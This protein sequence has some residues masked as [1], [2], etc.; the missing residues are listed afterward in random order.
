MTDVTADEFVARAA[1]MREVLRERQAQCE[2]L[3]RLPD[4]TNREYIEAGFFRVLQPR[5]FGG[6]ELGLDAFLRISIELAR[7][8]PSSGWVYA[9]TAGHA[10]TVTMWPEQGQVELFGDGD[11]RCPFSNLPARAIPGRGRLSHRR[12]VGLR[13]G[14]RHGHSLHRRG[15]G[16]RRRQPAAGRHPL[17]GLPALPP[18]PADAAPVRAGI[19]AAP[20]RVDVP[21]RPRPG[22]GADRHGAGGAQAGGRD[23]DRPGQEAVETGVPTGDEEQRRLL[24]VCQQVVELATAAVDIVFRTAGTSATRKGE[25]VE[26]C[27][28]DVHMIRTHVT[29]QFDRTYENVGQLRLG[30]PPAGFF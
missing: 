7:G 19:A 6:H 21:A 4:E 23:M 30:M 20:R 17:G 13:L 16:R 26:R 1:A 15:R 11:F 12:L 8:C 18:N 25:A 29:M 10:H 5:R 28:R 27:F 24:L 9:L 3:G 14:L 2:E 22:D